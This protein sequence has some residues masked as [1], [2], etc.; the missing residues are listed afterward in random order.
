M[1]LSIS[2][3]LSNVDFAI[4]KIGFSTEIPDLD[5][6]A[7]L[8]LNTEYLSMTADPG[9]GII[10]EAKFYIWWYLYSNA[11]YRLECSVTPFTGRYNASNVFEFE[12][13]AKTDNGNDEGLSSAGRNVVNVLGEYNP[14]DGLYAGFVEY[15]IPG[16]TYTDKIADSYSADITINLVSST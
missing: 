3:D 11:S 9:K 8:P 7:N 6:A 16:F 10:N 5:D 2:I 12:S 4:E 14:A 1:Q 15:T 13:T